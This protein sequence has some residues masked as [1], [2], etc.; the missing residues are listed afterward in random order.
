MAR[1]RSALVIFPTFLSATSS[2]V[3][4]GRQLQLTATVAPANATDKSLTW[5]SSNT[6]VA[7]V[8]SEGLVTGV[9]IGTATITAT[10][11]DGS[12]ASGSI[13]LNV[14]EAKAIVTQITL[15]AASN[16]LYTGFTLP[17]TALT[18]PDDAA[19]T[20]V[21]WTSSNTA[22]ATVDSE[23]IVTGVAAGSV[24]ITATANDGGG[25]TGSIALTVNESYPVNFDKSATSTHSG[26][27]L[28]AIRLQP[29][30]GSQQ[31]I[32][33]A[34]ALYSAIY[35]NL[36]ATADGFSCV[37]GET[38]TPEFYY[39]ATGGWMSGYVYV[40]TGND[41]TFSY[42]DTADG[43][44]DLMSISTHDFNSGEDNNLKTNKIISM[45]SFTAPSAPGT[46]RMRYK[47]DWASTDPGGNTSNSIITN[48]GAIVDIL[49]KVY[50]RGDVNGD[51]RVNVVDIAALNA[52]ING[53]A[54]ITEVRTDINRDGNVDTDDVSA[55][56]QIIL[57]AK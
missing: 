4:E 15:S 48:G 12:H 21:T 14:V 43:L 49:L 16:S 8:S 34:S 1:M 55:L 44:T 54:T 27:Y 52:A 37:A 3:A 24:T 47:V 23:G 9:S 40:D 26:R 25:A 13:T 22:V 10:A 6:A 53:N 36:T 46:Y 35:Y 11:N 7:T 19:D 2:N 56:Q 28:Q 41:G 45:A 20:S 30:N 39:Q 29:A 17:V 51:G 31:S 32:D 33:V 38:L 57:N 5:T 42:S 18:A 50:A